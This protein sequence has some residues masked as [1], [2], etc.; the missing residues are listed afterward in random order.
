MTDKGLEE[1]L[2]DSFEQHQDAIPGSGEFEE[3]D[4]SRSAGTPLEAD[5]AD[6]AEQARGL[7][8][9]EDDYR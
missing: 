4:D 1:P 7:D 6:V 5:E 3:S 8:F 2:P 9:A